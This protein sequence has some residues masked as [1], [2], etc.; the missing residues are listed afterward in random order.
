MK[1]LARNYQNNSEPIIYVEANVI[2][3]DRSQQLMVIKGPPI[4]Q[5][6]GDFNVKLRI[7]ESEYNA[8][9][10]EAVRCDYLDLTPEIYNYDINESASD[11][12]DV[13][14]I[15]SPKSIY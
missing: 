10:C 11:P 12:I 2:Y 8:M 3:Y 6:S 1:I 14:N 13:S 4:Y 5:Y 15:R 7:S 9:L